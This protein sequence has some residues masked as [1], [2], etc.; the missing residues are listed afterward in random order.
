MTDGKWGIEGVPSLDYRTIPVTERNLWF[1]ERSIPLFDLLDFFPSD[2]VGPPEVSLG[3]SDGSKST[4]ITIETDQGWT[5][6]TDITSDSK[7][8][9][10]KSRNRG[11]GKWVVQAQLSPGDVIILQKISDYKYRLIKQSNKRQSHDKQI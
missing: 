8:F 1:L 6:Q 3:H 11:T 7:V 5:F 10:N 2:S 4:K 9:R